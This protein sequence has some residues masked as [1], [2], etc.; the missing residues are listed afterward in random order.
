MRYSCRQE[1][2]S[3]SVRAWAG[4]RSETRRTSLP[5]PAFQRR[6]VPSLLPDAIVTPSGAKA[7]LSDQILV[8]KLNLPN[9]PARSDY[10][11]LQGRSPAADAR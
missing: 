4:R 1:R 11:K 6:I 9:V 10:L 8:A 7:T 5:A 3:P 2:K